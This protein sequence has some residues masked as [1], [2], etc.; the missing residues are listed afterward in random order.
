[1]KGHHSIIRKLIFDSSKVLLFFSTTKTSQKHSSADALLCKG[2]TLLCL[3]T[4]AHTHTLLYAQQDENINL[5]TQPF[6]HADT[7]MDRV[8][9]LYR[10]TF[11]YL[12]RIRDTWMC[13]E[14]E[15]TLQCEVWSDGLIIFNLWS[16]TTIR[17]NLLTI[18]I[19][20]QNWFKILPVT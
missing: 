4:W 12:H 19:I 9:G 20:C 3:F 7:L 2:T 16:F 6:Q 15:A 5:I 11:M 8:R 18:V 17:Y 10:K 1:M 13:L 14:G